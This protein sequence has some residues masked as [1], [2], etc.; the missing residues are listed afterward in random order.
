MKQ[1]NFMNNHRVVLLD[2]CPCVLSIVTILL[3]KK[4]LNII[5]QTH[6]GD[7]NERISVLLTCSDIGI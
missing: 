3:F 4:H 2:P 1:C 5:K 6:T 7:Y